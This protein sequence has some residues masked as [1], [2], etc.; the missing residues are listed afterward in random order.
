LDS[1]TST[2]GNF[3]LLNRLLTRME[4]ILEINSWRYLM[5]TP[6]IPRTTSDPVC[7]RS[8]R[9]SRTTADGTLVFLG[10]G[11][12]AGDILAPQE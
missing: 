1:C 9:A 3:R 6:L 12:I 5:R 4:R 10:A 11:L 7:L 8:L 2:G